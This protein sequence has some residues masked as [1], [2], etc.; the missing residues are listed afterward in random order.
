MNAKPWAITGVPSQ[1]RRSM[2]RC[3][4]SSL[5]TQTP[6]FAAAIFDMHGLIIDSERAIIVAWNLSHLRLFTVARVGQSFS[7][8]ST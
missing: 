3:F 5:L 2:S 7:A 1:V 6:M 4:D 8:E